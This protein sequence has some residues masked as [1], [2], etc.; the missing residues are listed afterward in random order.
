MALRVE[1]LFLNRVASDKGSIQSGFSVSH[2]EATALKQ[3][4]CRSATPLAAMG[5]IYD[6]LVSKII[7]YEKHGYTYRAAYDRLSL[8]A[9]P[10]LE[11]PRVKRALGDNPPNRDILIIG[12]LFKEVF[13][14]GGHTY[15]KGTNKDYINARVNT[16]LH[17]L[18]GIKV[19]LIWRDVVRQFDANLTRQLAPLVHKSITPTKS[20]AEAMAC[21]DEVVQGVFPFDAPEAGA[22][23]AKPPS[24]RAPASARVSSPPPG[25]LSLASAF[26]RAP[27]AAASLPFAL[28]PSR[29]L[30]KPLSSSQPRTLPLASAFRRASSAGLDLGFAADTKTGETRAGMSHKGGYDPFSAALLPAS[31]RVSSLPPGTLPFRRAPAAAA[32]A[33]A[34]AADP[35]GKPPER[36][37]FGGSSSGKPRP[38][39]GF[40]VP[41]K[42]T[43]SV[44]PKGPSRALAFGD[45]RT[46]PGDC[47]PIAVCELLRRSMLLSDEYG[48]PV[49]VREAME[50]AL[51]AR[52]EFVGVDARNAI[53]R[54]LLTESLR[55]IDASTG[56]HGHGSVTLDAIINFF[57]HGDFVSGRCTYARYDKP[58]ALEPIVRS[59]KGDP[60]PFL[61]VICFRPGHYTAIVPNIEKHG[62]FLYLNSAGGRC[63]EL[64]EAALKTVVSMQLSVIV[65]NLSPGVEARL[66][67][68]AAAPR[69][70]YAAKSSGLRA[71]M[72][73]LKPSGSSTAAG[74]ISI[75]S[76]ATG[77]PAGLSHFGREFYYFCAGKAKIE[78][79]GGLLTH[80][81]VLGM[82]ARDKELVHTFIQ[83]LFPVER[84]SGNPP[85]I[86]AADIEKLKGNRYVQEALKS[87][88]TAMIR[89]WQ[90]GTPG[91]NPITSHNNKRI[92]R[93]VSSMVS[94]FDVFPKMEELIILNE[95]LGLINTHLNY[96]R[97]GHVKRGLESKAAYLNSLQGMLERKIQALI[98]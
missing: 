40:L 75:D 93:A 96:D 86:T 98:R 20:H 50:R 57:Q 67:E 73:A 55:L 32:A 52:H 4:V 36:P 91:S 39:F 63:E 69:A 7:M 85:H 38:A 6:Y 13:T 5:E 79:N 47:G 48:D 37:R 66:F 56:V 60:T 88:M 25:T 24:S 14:K 74:S 9:N 28:A 30:P 1:P 81:Q 10:I 3:R 45:Y 64:D 76:G 82:S 8:K 84:G 58:V 17:L 94:L 59:C 92:I 65:V 42:R 68:P 97:V 95:H 54:G 83:R 44:R 53:E 23:A 11:D 29:A 19:P 27:A 41:P 87:S 77:A 62:H 80:A 2:R 12:V 70:R 43:P 34:A 46:I 72:P 18:Y 33:G 89:H 90:S 15:P 78:V 21:F 49:K 31:A 35:S 22:A 26:S 51:Q 71:A 16:A 61:G